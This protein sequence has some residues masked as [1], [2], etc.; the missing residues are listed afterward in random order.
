[1]TKEREKKKVY[2]AKQKQKQVVNIFT[3]HNPRAQRR[4]RPPRQQGQLPLI[5]TVYQNVPMFHPLPTHPQPVGTASDILTLIRHQ[6]EHKSRLDEHEKRLQTPHTVS[7]GN[8]DPHPL[9]NV[10]TQPLQEPVREAQAPR[11]LHPS[12]EAA[13]RP[14]FNYMTE[15]RSDEAQGGGGTIRLTKKG[16]PDKRFGK[17]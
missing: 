14:D 4:S 16:Q 17:R 10:P 1:M 12:F 6:A 13:A 9:D 15:E 11:R 8:R 5:R 3:Q 7:F 2:L